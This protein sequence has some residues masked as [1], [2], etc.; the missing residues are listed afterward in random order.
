[1]TPAPTFEHGVLRMEGERDER[2]EAARLVLLRPQAE[3]MVDALLV[4]LDMAVEH[5]AMRRDPE[6]VRRVVDVEPDVRMLLARRH[7]PAHA[8]GE[9]LCA[10]ARQR[11]EAGVLERA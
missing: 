6:A 10:A 5:R 7:E 11:A 4:R 1:M 3:E 8:V 9:D 2:E